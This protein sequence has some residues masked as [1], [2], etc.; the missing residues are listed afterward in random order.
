MLEPE[1]SGSLPPNPGVSG[2]KTRKE[3]ARRAMRSS[4]IA[5]VLGVWWSRT[6]RGAPTG[7]GG[8]GAL[9]YFWSPADGL[10]DA[11][12]ANPTAEL[13]VTTTY[14]VTVTDEKGCEATDQVT[15]KWS[16][17]FRHCFK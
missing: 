13:D 2:A 14:T 11:S 7:S 17:I 1:G 16:R 5:P 10:D 4:Y 9:S 15:E 8:K 6:K 12:A 3:S